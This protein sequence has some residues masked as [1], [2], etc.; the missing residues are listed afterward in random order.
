MRAMMREMPELLYCCELINPTLCK[1]TELVTENTFVEFAHTTSNTKTLQ[2][3]QHNRLVSGQQ[4]WSRSAT[5]VC[6]A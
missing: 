1:Q 5:L 6:P 2:I 3:M 4:R